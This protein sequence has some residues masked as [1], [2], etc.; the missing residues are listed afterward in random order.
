MEEPSTP[1]LSKLVDQLNKE[2]LETQ[3]LMIKVQDGDMHND[4]Y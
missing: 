3:S 4:A 2:S 1:R